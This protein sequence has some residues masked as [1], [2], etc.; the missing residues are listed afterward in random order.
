MDLSLEKYTKIH[1]PGYVIEIYC[2]QEVQ[3]IVYGNRETNPKILP[4]NKDTFYDIASLTKVYTAVL[5]YMAYEEGKIDLY[6]SVKDVDSRFQNLETVRI[7]DLLSHNQEIWT[8][9]YLGT[10]KDKEDFYRILFSAQ[11]KNTFPTYIDADYIILSTL[12]ENIYATSFEHLLQEKIFK[13]LGLTNTTVSPKG[14]NIASNNFEHLNGE[15]VDF[16][17]PGVLHDTK[18][19]RARELGI[20]TGH[21]SIFTTG[22]DLFLFLKSFLDCTLLKKETILMMLQHDDRNKQNFEL[23]SQF[24]SGIDINQ[25]YEQVL[26][27]N[28]NFKAMSTYNYMGTRYRNLIKD[29]NDVPSVCS[30]QSIVFSG[31]TGPM[32]MIDFEKNIIVLIL[33]NVMHNTRLNRKERKKLTEEILDTICKKIY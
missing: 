20:V 16:I 10:A 7:L 15:V 14:E 24:V 12:L 30:E 22:R 18:A 31:Y 27:K 33:C 6:S 5:V 26:R 2:N 17:Y 25:M 29:M 3:E 11:V 28:S 21:A 13:P 19:R 23:L 1:S 8:D 4:C 32:F 9:G